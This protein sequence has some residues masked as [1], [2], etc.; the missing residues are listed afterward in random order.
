MLYRDLQYL[1]ELDAT[2][3]KERKE[4]KERERAITTIPLIVSF[5]EIDL[6]ALDDAFVLDFGETWPASSSSLVSVLLVPIYRLLPS[7]P[8]TVLYTAADRLFL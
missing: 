2:K 6:F 1:N 4:I 3:E 5:R 7:V 8:S